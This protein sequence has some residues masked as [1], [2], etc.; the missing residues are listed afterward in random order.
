[1]LCL[2]FICGGVRPFMLF[3]MKMDWFGDGRRLSEA[4]LRRCLSCFHLWWCTAVH[5]VS[6]ENNLMQ[7]DKDARKFCVFWS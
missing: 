6:F 4:S 5:V 7:R 1:M 2:I 3:P